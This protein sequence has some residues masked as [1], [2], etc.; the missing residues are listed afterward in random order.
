M[1]LQTIAESFS[2][3]VPA[4]LVTGLVLVGGY[5]YDQSKQS[6]ERLATLEAITEEYSEDVRE[7]K[8]SILRLENHLIGEKG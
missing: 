3:S 4:W 6:S 7:I 1:P 2:E 8:Q 5:M